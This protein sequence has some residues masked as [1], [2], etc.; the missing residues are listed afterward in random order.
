MYLQLP[1]TLLCSSARHPLGSFAKVKLCL[2]YPDEEPDCVKEDDPP[3]RY[4]LQVCLTT[5][6][7]FSTV[8][9]A[10][11]KLSEKCCLGHRIGMVISPALSM[12]HSAD[13]PYSAHSSDS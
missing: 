11:C 5:L 2:D 7:K 3:H 1:Q 10:V 9:N 12:P 8:Q 4:P 6:S 13:F